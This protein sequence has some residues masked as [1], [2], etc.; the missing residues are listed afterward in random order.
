MS[1]RTRK[2]IPGDDLRAAAEAEAAQRDADGHFPE[3]AFEA[4]R[5]LGVVTNPPLHNNEI[6]RLLRYLAAIGRGNLSVGRIFEGHCNALLLIQQFGTSSQHERFRLVASGGDLF[7][8]WDAEI[9]GESLRLEAGRLKGKKS[10]ASGA[11]GLR[12]AVVTASVAEGKQMIV[13][14][15]EGLH[16]ERDWWRPLGMKASGS[17]VVSFNDLSV[18]AQSMLGRPNDYLREPWFSAGAIRFLA[19][20]V[21]G[22]HALLDAT[23]AHL[24]E[25]QRVQD[26]HQQYRIG[27]MAADV[28]SGYAW[29]EYVA[30][31]WRCIE[32][33]P[34]VYL[35]AAVNAARVAIERVALNVLE[36][37][38]RSIGAAGMIAPHPYERIMRDLRTYL[39]Q[40]N[41]DAAHCGV[42][43]ALIEET[44]TPDGYGDLQIDDR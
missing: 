19:V 6:R 32:R 22:M 3:A 29:L 23:V 20:H 11:D 42:G 36:T 41:P 24:G 37:A 5:R 2:W 27:N 1:R 15:I 13:V 10:F 44:W 17:H 14:P 35:A 4:L 38:E 28:A 16:I 39:R 9:A 30:D 43:K 26:P 40:P 12:Y 21:G 7:G 18:D 31:R 34:A 25:T 8:V 33:V